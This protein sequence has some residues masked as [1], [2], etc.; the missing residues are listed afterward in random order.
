MALGWHLRHGNHTVIRGYR[1]SV[2]L[3]WWREDHLGGNIGLERAV[4]RDLFKTEIAV[5]W[6]P[7]AASK[8]VATE[9]QALHVAQRDV[10]PASTTGAAMRLRSMKSSGL[11]IEHLGLRPYNP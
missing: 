7:A 1:V 5:E 3:R 8:L 10:L 4:P 9:D 11:R 6:Y 2:P